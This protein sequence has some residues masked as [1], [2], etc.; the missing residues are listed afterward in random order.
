M[1]LLWIRPERVHV[2]VVVVMNEGEGGGWGRSGLNPPQIP[3]LPVHVLTGELLGALSKLQ[4]VSGLGVGRSRTEFY[5]RAV[6][7]PTPA[8]P[9]PCEVYTV[10]NGARF[11]YVGVPTGAS[12]KETGA[13]LA[14][15]RLDLR[16][17]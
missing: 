16:E 17:G 12:P 5:S 6:P 11:A 2:W 15:A 14:Q 7:G 4:L 1:W 10:A 9:I 3:H 13:A 8:G